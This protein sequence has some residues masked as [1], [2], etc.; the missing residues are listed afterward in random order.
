MT[1]QFH[2]GNLS[3]ETQN[4]GSKQYMHPY[5]HWSAIY[6]SQDL[7]AAPVPIRTG[8]GKKAAVH[9]HDGILFSRKNGRQLLNNFWTHY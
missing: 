9:L 7:K 4:T 1:Q 8:V 6:N 3:K 5:I 2:F